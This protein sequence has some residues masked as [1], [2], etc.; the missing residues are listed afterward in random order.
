MPLSHLFVVASY[1]SL[2]P[3]PYSREPVW[4]SG[5][6]SQVES[7]R[8]VRVALVT[9]GTSWYGS[10]RPVTVSGLSPFCQRM[11]RSE[12]RHM[13]PKVTQPVSRG[14]G[15]GSHPHPAPESKAYS[16]SRP[17]LKVPTRYWGCGLERGRPCS[18]LSKCPLWEDGMRG[19]TEGWGGE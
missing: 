1:C 8:A 11:T 4:L 14:P 16:F 2:Y 3:W 10:C 5:K 19:P 15:M 6:D 18:A 12:S 17:A 7:S 9:R 13:L